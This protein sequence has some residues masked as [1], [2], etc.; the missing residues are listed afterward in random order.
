M[1]TDFSREAENALQTALPIARAFNSKLIVLHILEMAGEGPLDEINISSQIREE[2]ERV[3]ESLGRCRKLHDIDQAGIEFEEII[4]IGNPGKQI[5]NFINEADVD[6]VVMGTKSAWGLNDILL[7]TTTDKLLRRVNCPVLSVNKVVPVESFKKIVFPTTTFNKES[8]LIQIIKVF[9]RLFDSKIYLV[10]INTPLHFM[11]DKESI[12]LLDNYAAKIEL[13]NYT[14]YVYS[15]NLEED[16]IRDFAE[17][18]EAG[19]IAVATSAHTGLW[20]IIQGSVTKELVSHSTRPVLTV[21]LD[22]N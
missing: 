3:H 12:K 5:E 18:K 8:R 21:K 14:S 2:L 16:G 7:G 10:R 9:Q 1:P 4:R 20:K 11:S 22:A 6:F 17:L 19:I 13:A 15:H